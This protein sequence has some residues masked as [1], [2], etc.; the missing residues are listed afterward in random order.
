M[1]YFNAYLFAGAR[2]TKNAVDGLLYALAIAPND[3]KLRIIAVR[4]LLVDGRI[5]D[6]KRYFAPLAFEPHASKIWREASIKVMAALNSG[7]GRVAIASLDQA[8]KALKGDD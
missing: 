7:D 4:Q 8:E 5:A 2:P 1:Q 3:S 6:A